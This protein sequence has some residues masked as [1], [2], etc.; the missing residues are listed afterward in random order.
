MPP[1]EKR[2]KEGAKKTSERGKKKKVG[3]VVNFVWRVRGPQDGS[4]PV[5]W[6]LGCD[7]ACG[8]H[9]RRV[10]PQIALKSEII[11]IIKNK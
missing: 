7:R 2:R 9:G 5:E 11:K 4:L 1:C 3:F 8:T 6:V 10:A